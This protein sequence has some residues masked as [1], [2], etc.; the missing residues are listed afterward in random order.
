MTGESAIENFATAA[1]GF[2]GHL[3][4]RTALELWREGVAQHDMM[5][6]NEVRKRVCPVA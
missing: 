5:H 3:G 6:K 1:M 2:D 4:G